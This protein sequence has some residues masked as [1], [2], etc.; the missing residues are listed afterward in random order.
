MRERNARS[1]VSGLSK[2]STMHPVNALPRARQWEAALRPE[3]LLEML[4][5]APADYR[6]F[7]ASDLRR[8]A[9]WCARD[10]GAAEAGAI[11]YRVLH[12]AEKAA[13]GQLPLRLLAAERH[14]ASDLA[15][16]AGTIGVRQRS[17]PAAV[18][19][20]AIVTADHD[21]LDAARGAAY[22]AA[23]AAVLR[24]GEPAGIVVRMRLS[25]A[26]RFFISNPF[27]RESS[28]DAVA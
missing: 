22:Y 26:L 11:P 6:A 19:L 2:G 23:L 25:S 1:T 28:R 20:A 9:C 5:P 21:P 12:A 13:A 10:A 3:T 16:A 15:A 4:Q 8:F 18:Q 14:S 24:D 7:I 27:T 17:W